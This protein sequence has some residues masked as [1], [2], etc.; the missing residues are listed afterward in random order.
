M[1]SVIDPGCLAEANERFL[2]V[3]TRIQAACTSA[4]RAASEITLVGACKRQPLDRIAA[5]VCAGLSQLGENYVQAAQETRP[6]LA[7]L[8]AAHFADLGTPAPAPTWR[9]IGHLQ[10]NK[11]G[12]AAGLFH[13]VDSVDNPRL[14]RALESRARDQGEVVEA[15]IQVNLS[16]E[17]SKSGCPEG[18]LPGL[19]ASCAEFSHLRVV[20]LMTMPAPDPDPEQARETFARLRALRDTLSRREGGA[21]LHHLNMGMS[22]DLEVAIEEGATLIRVG[23]DLFGERTPPPSPGPPEKTMP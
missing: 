4:G 5:A 8:L 16:G 10:R 19:L 23:T 11:A 21:H 12:P 13:A 20:G 7:D 18:D 17:S 1:S 9:M 14:A 6:R 22:G 3:R 15:C 2:A